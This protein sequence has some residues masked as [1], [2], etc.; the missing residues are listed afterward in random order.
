VRAVVIDRSRSFFF[1]YIYDRVC[2]KMFAR[3]RVFVVVVVIVASGLRSKSGMSRRKT[4][5]GEVF[6]FK[7]NSK[8]YERYHQCRRHDLYALCK[9]N[10]ILSRAES[11]SRTV[12]SINRNVVRD[13]IIYIYIMYDL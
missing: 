1:F 4:K 13:L 11:R 7:D 5:Q 3:A 6:V 8:T 9:F 12:R 10:D 2:I